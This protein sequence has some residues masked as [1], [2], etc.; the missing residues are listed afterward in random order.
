VSQFEEYEY[1]AEDAQR[2]SERRQNTTQ[3]YV[4]VNAAIF[5]VSALLIKDIGL[6]GW[7]LALT[8][9]PLFLTG[10]LVSVI[11][12]RIILQHSVLIGWRY[13]QLRQMEQNIAG[14]YQTYTK[15]WLE[16]FEPH[17]GKA[18]LGFSALEVWLPRLFLVLYFAYGVGLVVAVATGHL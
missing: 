8:T 4:T 12:R 11:W 14:S 18:R 17:Q 2:L 13:E 3:I 1:F 9:L 7:I 6:R 16:F 15:E 10:V 5:A